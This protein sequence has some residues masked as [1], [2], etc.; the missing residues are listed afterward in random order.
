MPSKTLRRRPASLQIIGKSLGGLMFPA[1][2]F[3][4]RV[5]RGGAVLELRQR[6]GKRSGFSVVPP[7]ERP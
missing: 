2:R 4:L 7:D 5:E 6:R 3:K 1:V